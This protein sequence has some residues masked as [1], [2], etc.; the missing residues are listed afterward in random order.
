MDIEG[1]RN[2]PRVARLYR[3]WNN[4]ANIALAMAYKQAGG[5]DRDDDADI[6]WGTVMG[7]WRRA[8]ETIGGHGAL[9]KAGDSHAVRAH[10]ASMS[11]HVRVAWGW[12]A[13]ACILDRETEER[14]RSRWNRRL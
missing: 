14:M 9:G 6:F 3:P 8:Y 7:N 2:I 1:H 4:L 13:R 10:W 11:H 5:L 12:M